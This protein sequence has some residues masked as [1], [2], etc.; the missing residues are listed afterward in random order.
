MAMGWGG[1]RKKSK[2]IKREIEEIKR[3]IEEIEEDCTRLC[4]RPAASMSVETCK[5]H[6]QRRSP[7]NV[8]PE[9][10]RNW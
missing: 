9:D 6:Q 7:F 4:S 10:R 8:E 2:E 1:G 5:L 3:E